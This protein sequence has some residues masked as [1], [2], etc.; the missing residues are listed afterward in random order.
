MDSTRVFIAVELT[1]PAREAIANLVHNLKGELNH[2]R[3]LEANQMHVTLKFIGEVT[4][5]RLPEISQQISKACNRIQPFSLTLQGLGAFPPQSSPKVLW[6]GIAGRVDLLRIIHD[7]LEHSLVSLNIERE[8][9]AYTAHLTLGR[10][11]R[12]AD[13]NRIT[14]VMQEHLS[15]EFAK[16]NVDRIALYSSTRQA[17]DTLYK[18]IDVVE[19]RAESKDP[20]P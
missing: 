7:R 6:V 12:D 11:D 5:N 8:A 20:C 13:V 19:L 16:L 14:S 18:V 17:D 2:V 9:R 1:S 4:N 3:W 10:V 15:T